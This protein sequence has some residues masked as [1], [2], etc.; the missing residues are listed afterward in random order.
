MALRFNPPPG[1]PP[2]PPGWLPPPDWKPDPSWPT[3]PPGWQYVIND[4]PDDGPEDDGAVG[5]ND[6]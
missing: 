1:W 3:A 2:P 5:W 4:P 6:I